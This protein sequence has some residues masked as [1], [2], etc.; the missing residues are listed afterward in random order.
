M[1]QWTRCQDTQVSHFC[2]DHPVNYVRHPA[3]QC[4]V[5]HRP[6]IGFWT[7]VTL[8]ME[9]GGGWRVEG[10]GRRE[11]GGGG[12]RVEGG[13]WR[14][15]GGGWRV[16]G[17]GR[18]EEGGGR[19]EEGGG[20]REEGGGRREEGGG[21]REEGRGVPKGWDWAGWATA[22]QYAKQSK[23]KK[24]LSLRFDALQYSLVRYFFLSFFCLAASRGE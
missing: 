17:G 12:R 19:R 10:G 9:E 8:R 21:R 4:W 24:L 3:F 13:G 14:E 23:K 1:V 15:E 20:R 7:W 18:R 16:E 11:G 5:W 22:R 2:N 6:G